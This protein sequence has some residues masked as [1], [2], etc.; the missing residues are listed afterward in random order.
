MFCG[1]LAVVAEN[2]LLFYEKLAVVLRNHVGLLELAASLRE[3]A[4]S[5]S[6]SF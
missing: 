3:L 6:F 5:F 1:K 2:L 4:A